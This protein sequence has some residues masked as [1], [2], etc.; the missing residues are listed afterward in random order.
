MRDYTRLVPAPKQLKTVRDV[1][2]EHLNHAKITQSQLAEIWGIQPVSARRL[3]SPH[4]KRANQIKPHMIDA[5]VKA[6]KLD[7]EDERE[8]HWLAA[9]ELGFKIGRLPR[10]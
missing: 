9:R 7:R 5:V 1:I 8:L 2:R 3:M 6:L 4:A 10:E